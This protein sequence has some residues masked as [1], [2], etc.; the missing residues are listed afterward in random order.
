LGTPALALFD[1]K[2]SVSKKVVTV[3]LGMIILATGIL[4]MLGSYRQYQSGEKTILVQALEKRESTGWCN[5]SL[6]T[7]YIAET[8]DGEKRYLFNLKEK[9][10][11]KVEV[12]S[13]YR[14]TF[15]PFQP[16]FNTAYQYPSLYETTGE[17]TR[18]EKVNY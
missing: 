13:C 15:F 7:D 5:R 17:I 18:I 8:S 4:I 14:F 12:D 9:I 3:F 6:C 2:E 16:L 11:E 10:W 1:R